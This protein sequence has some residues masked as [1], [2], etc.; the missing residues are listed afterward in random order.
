[1]QTIHLCPS[2]KSETQRLAYCAVRRS[3]VCAESCA[4]S[5]TDVFLLNLLYTHPSP[6]VVANSVVALNEVEA[7]QKEINL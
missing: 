1:M 5:D 3:L 6:S 2:C 4:L 7:L